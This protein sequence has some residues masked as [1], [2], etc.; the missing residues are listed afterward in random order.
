MSFE[1]GTDNQSLSK[2]NLSAEEDRRLVWKGQPAFSEYAFLWFF[3]LLSLIRGGVAFFMGNAGSG[4]IYLLGTVLFIGFATVLHRASRYTIT[5]AAIHKTAGFFGKEETILP[6]I[7]I[8][9]LRVE[10]GPLDRLLGIGTL[11]LYRKGTDRVERLRG[12]TDPEVVLRK[13]EALL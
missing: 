13:I 4:S 1:T 6:L 8:V 7:E 12:I 10:Q 9:S 3:A 11:L 5:R 2:Q